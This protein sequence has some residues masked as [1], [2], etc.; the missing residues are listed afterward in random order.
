MT[1]KTTKPTRTPPRERLTYRVIAQ[2][3]TVYEVEADNPDQAIDR[4]IDG[5]GREVDG[6]TQHIDAVLLCPVCRTALNNSTT[7]EREQLGGALVEEP[8]YCDTCDRE[9]VW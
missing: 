4:M 2:R 6:S 1:I 7:R 9:V 5:R 3:T 8:T